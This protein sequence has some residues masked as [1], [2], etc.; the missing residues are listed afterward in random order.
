MFSTSQ[1]KESMNL[2]AGITP[3]GGTWVSLL[4]VSGPTV[5]LLCKIPW[6]CA[7]AL[8]DP[9]ESAEGLECRMTRSSVSCAS[10][11]WDFHFSQFRSSC[12]NPSNLGRSS[13][14]VFLAKRERDAIETSHAS[15]IARPASL[16]FRFTYLQRVINDETCGS[17]THQ[18][19]ILYWR[20][21]TLIASPPVLVSPMWSRISRRVTCLK[22]VVSCFKANNPCFFHAG[23]DEFIPYA[24]GGLDGRL[25]IKLAGSFYFWCRR[26][27]LLLLV[28]IER[29]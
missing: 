17:S 4:N 20:P 15:D 21:I 25:E 16:A 27:A 13:G 2:S 3:G 1:L 6:M 28:Q 24:L 7:V 23:E 26:T 19:N 29:L 11:K 8:D 9:K 10:W 18:D 12:G 14:N 5:S 22:R